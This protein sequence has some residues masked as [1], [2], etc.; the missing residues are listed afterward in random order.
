V[1]INITRS[2][3][4]LAFPGSNYKT[5]EEELSFST[6]L[7]LQEPKQIYIFK[8]STDKRGGPLQKS[9]RDIIEPG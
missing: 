4:P 3:L 6:N 8:K 9:S 2:R 5:N 7:E 1:N